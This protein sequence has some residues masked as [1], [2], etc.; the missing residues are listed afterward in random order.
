MKHLNSAVRTILNQL[1]LP[2]S[3]ILQGIF[4]KEKRSGV[5]WCLVT[6]TTV[7][8]FGFIHA[9]LNIDLV[10]GI[11]PF[12]LMLGCTSVTCSFFSGWMVD[13]KSKRMNTRMVCQ[14]AQLRLVTSIFVAIYTV[15][16]ATYMGELHKL[17]FSGW[18]AAVVGF[19]SAIKFIIC[20]S[21]LQPLGSLLNE[22]EH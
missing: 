22:L 12:G 4:L 18:N 5:Q 10:T 8:I 2:L 9:N 14:M 15:G 20:T 3:A 7:G 16:Y 1:K 13:V 17:P 21:M 19:V 6:A 11:S